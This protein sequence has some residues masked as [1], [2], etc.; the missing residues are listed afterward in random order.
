MPSTQKNTRNIRRRKVAD[1]YLD[2][3]RRFPLR[4]I[5]SEAEYDEGGDLLL[6]LAGRASRG[7][8]SAGENDYLDMLGRMVREYDEK[9]SSLLRDI[10]ENPMTP[11]EVLQTLMEENGMNTVS[12]GKLIG[13]S[14]HVSLILNAKRELSKANIR[15]LAERFKVSPALF[16]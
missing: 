12:L 6:E 9:H 15:T 5:R 11:V 13:G 10:R 1:D 14:G 16:I 7:C 3:I 8:L 4:P 2:L